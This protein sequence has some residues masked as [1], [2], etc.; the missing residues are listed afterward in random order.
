MCWQGS[1]L[2]SEPPSLLGWAELSPDQPGPHLHHWPHPCGALRRE[3][4]TVVR[5]TS[6]LQKMRRRRRKEGGGC[7]LVKV[8]GVRTAV[9]KLGR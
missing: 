1:L 2:L 6:D 5:M 7:D 4:G 3:S 8:R 9:L